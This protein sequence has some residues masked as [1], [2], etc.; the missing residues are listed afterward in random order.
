[1]ANITKAGPLGSWLDRIGDVNPQLMRELRGRL[2]PMPILVTLGSAIGLH[3]FLAY[4]YSSFAESQTSGILGFLLTFFRFLSPITI[5]IACHQ[6]IDNLSTEV[7]HG[8]INALRLSPQA[9]GQILVGKM[10]GVPVLVYLFNLLCL[11]LY[12]VVSVSAGVPLLTI[13]TTIISDFTQMI[14]WLTTSLVIALILG[15]NKSISNSIGTL[16]IGS[17]LMVLN[18]PGLPIPWLMSMTLTVIWNYFFCWKFANAQLDLDMDLSITWSSKPQENLL[19]PLSNL[20][21]SE[22]VKT[23]KTPQRSIGF[24]EPLLDRIGDL[25]PQLMRE[26]R[27]KL[28]S[29]N[30]LLTLFASITLQLFNLMTF[31]FLSDPGGDIFWLMGLQQL[32]ILIGCY[33]LIRNW[34]IEEEQGTFNPIRLS[35]QSVWSILWGKFIGVPSLIYLFNLS[36]LPLYFISS[37]MGRFPI[38]TTFGF[39]GVGLAQMGL[40]F[41]L[42]LLFTS[43]TA[44]MQGSKA[45]CGSVLVGFCLIFQS[46]CNSVLLSQTDIISDSLGVCFFGIGGFG[47]ISCLCW[48]AIARRFHRPSATLWSKGQT[49][50]V[51]TIVTALGLILGGIWVLPGLSFLILAQ[52]LVLIQPRQVLLDWASHPPDQL[53]L[54]LSPI[55]P[56]PRNISRRRDLIW[57][58][59]SP[60]FLAIGIHLGIIAAELGVFALLNLGTIDQI[61]AS[62]GPQLGG[63]LLQSSWLFLILGVIQVVRLRSKRSGMVLTTLILL[64]GLFVPPLLM[65]IG[66]STGAFGDYSRL[67]LLTAPALASLDATTIG[68]LIA[69]L[70]FQWTGVAVIGNQFDR[71]LRRLAKSEFA[72]SLEPISPQVS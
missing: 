69:A 25:N 61:L 1:M 18:S 58:E 19:Q 59:M 27:G 48:Q 33:Q 24:L 57:G 44:K 20:S 55:P 9:S 62:Y 16:L 7:Q 66:A 4:L 12:G 63:L 72:A 2:K 52:G 35:P 11:P 50:A 47:A 42:S 64:I 67:R 23:V 22:V 41:S 53:A 31:R 56:I 37:G 34:S 30:V 49:Y 10:L 65:A 17:G 46:L 26:L 54:E 45:L 70:C 6:L 8:T 3:V 28:T 60:P 13:L 14:C 68:P 32:T 43:L 38:A 71:T 51:T 15:K 40:W 39:L 21:S 29:S 5:V 36:F